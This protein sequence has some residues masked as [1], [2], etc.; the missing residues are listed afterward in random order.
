MSNP[1]IE[2]RLPFAA[3]RGI[4]LRRWRLQNFKSVR[5]AEVELRPLTVVVGANSAGKSTLLQS[6]RAASQAT[7]T[8]GYLYPLNG[9]GVRLGTVAEVKYR[10]P[11]NDEEP[12]I[13]G[14]DFDI[15]APRVVYR[16][17]RRLAPAQVGPLLATLSWEVKLGESKQ[18][19]G[20]AKIERLNVDLKPMDS[21]SLARNA[22]RVDRAWV[23]AIADDDAEDLVPVEDDDARSIP[24]YFSGQFAGADGNVLEVVDIL[25]TGGFPL[26]A[27]V[28][29]P[30]AEVLFEAWRDMLL[31]RSIQERDEIE[32]DL[33]TEEKAIEEVRRVLL[34]VHAAVADAKAEYAD[35]VRIELGSK[36]PETRSKIDLNIAS[37]ETFSDAVVE[38]L[39]RGGVQGEVPF[40]HRLDDLGRASNLASS[41]LSAGIRYL[42]PLRDEPRASYP[43][44]PEG[45]D[46]YVGPKGEF[47]A[48]VLQRHG[49]RKVS[50]PSP[51]PDG[52]IKTPRRPIQ[53]ITAVNRWAEYLDI[54][55]SFSVSDQGRFGIQMEVRQKDV[56]GD[57]DLTSVGTGVSQLLPVIVMC[58]QAPVGSLLLIEQ[59]EL[60]LNPR[61]QQRL[62]DFLL[63]IA[64]SG[65]HL[66]VE[67]HSEYLIS[68]LRRRVAE[69][70]DD[71]LQDTI[72]IYFAKR[73]D[74][75]TTY[76]PV[77]TNEYGGVEEWPENFFDQA[78]EEE[79]AILSAAVKKR[80]TKA[81]QSE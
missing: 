63:E 36:A 76:E 35:A 11:G 80:R 21:D 24:H 81:A 14:A 8:T 1:L 77:K 75:A 16:E 5:T 18:Q 67:T 15:R 39:T 38:E 6:I 27:S 7:G 50:V 51:Q 34:S 65:R 71:D 62:T 59:P 74:G 57:L 64:Q 79:H 66:I 41:Y 26:D 60:H 20:I 4:T 25:V 19:K 44:S 2:R 43:D 23:L 52:T 9:R 12:L 61:V 17:G 53:L 30:R 78:T 56:D 32:Q 48:A 45:D 29:R 46:S 22:P 47:T 10:G 73:V 70:L 55:E 54:G 58:L 13:I 31:R 69:D 49:D 72:G 33:F 40:P 37:S 3:R 28:M 68:R 42:G